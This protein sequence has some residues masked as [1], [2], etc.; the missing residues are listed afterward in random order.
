MS[1]FLTHSTDKF[2]IQQGH[3]FL[4]YISF[5]GYISR[6]TW[7]VGKPSNRVPMS[8]QPSKL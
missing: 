7:S 8:L 6:N 5:R 3:N 4:V 1:N 2:S